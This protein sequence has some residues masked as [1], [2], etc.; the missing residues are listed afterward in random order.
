MQSC[1]NVICFIGCSR[2]V[3]IL[4]FPQLTRHRTTI[5][6]LHSPPESQTKKVRQRISIICCGAGCSCGTLSW[7]Y[8]NN[9][10]KV[11]HSLELFDVYFQIH[12]GVLFL[13]RGVRSNKPPP[14][15]WHSIFS[16]SRSIVSLGVPYFVPC[17][18]YVSLQYSVCRQTYV[19]STVYW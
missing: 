1:N 18:K 5:R 14:C 13:R 15:G 10:I 16:I 4:G 8:N 19:A 11:I 9:Y 7:S 3:S 2:A 6:L 17:I 12:T